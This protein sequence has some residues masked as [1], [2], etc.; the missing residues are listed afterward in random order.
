MLALE[1]YLAEGEE[2]GERVSPFG[3]SGCEREA[4]VVSAMGEDPPDEV[5]EREMSE[6]DE[7]VEGGEGV[8]LRGMSI[9]SEN[10]REGKEPVRRR[11]CGAGIDDMMSSLGDEGG[12]VECVVVRIL[13][14]RRRKTFSLMGCAPGCCEGDISGCVMYL[15]RRNG[16]LRYYCV[17]SQASGRVCKYGVNLRFPRDDQIDSSSKT[18]RNLLQSCL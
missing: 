17:G 8:A 10:A 3:Q 11:V 1:V 6:A 18:P 15:G 9:A 5:G 7:D 2:T 12:E 4:N 14:K 16:R 13:L